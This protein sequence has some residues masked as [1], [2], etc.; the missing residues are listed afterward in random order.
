MGF[1]SWNCAACARS[2]LNVYSATVYDDTHWL[3]EIIAVS[4]YEDPPFNTLPE[5]FSS[6]DRSCHIARGMYGGYGML[7]NCDEIEYH[8]LKPSDWR[9]FHEACWLAVGSPDTWEAVSQF[10]I[11]SDAKDQGHFIDQRVIKIE[12]PDFLLH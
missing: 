11:N 4:R 2:I 9:M 10:R 8:D 6:S 5:R 3:C 7:D 1:F 12:K